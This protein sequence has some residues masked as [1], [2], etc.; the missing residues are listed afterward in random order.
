MLP[1]FAG[2]EVRE[3]VRKS[4]MP[5]HVDHDVLQKNELKDRRFTHPF[6]D[7]LRYNITEIQASGQF[8]VDQV[9]SPHDVLILTL[10]I[11][12]Q[13]EGK[14][15]R[16]LTESEIKAQTSGDPK[17]GDFRQELYWVLV[18]VWR[19]WYFGDRALETI[20]PGRYLY[21]RM[22]DEKL[23]TVPELAVLKAD[24]LKRIC[25][26]QNSLIAFTKNMRTVMPDY[27]PPFIN[28]DRKDKEEEAIPPSES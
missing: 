3:V 6:R 14:Y 11:D 23:H 5:E 1:E 28:Y 18:R 2:V 16:F 24:D 27:N 7:Q 4:W 13:G 17:I 25:P 21:N 8:T 15:K 22:I 19:R 26:S 10:S 20:K 9:L 12:R